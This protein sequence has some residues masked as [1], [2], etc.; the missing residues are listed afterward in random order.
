MTAKLNCPSCG[1]QVPFQS[2]ASVSATCPYCRSVLVRTDMK[3]EEIGKVAKLMDDMT[4]LQIGT[5]GRYKGRSFILLGRARWQWSAGFWNEWHLSYGGGASGWLAEA[6]GFM[7]VAHFEATKAVPAREK[8]KVGDHLVL[9][10]GKYQVEDMKEASCV[11]TEGEL[12]AIIKPG[13][14]KRT[15]DLTANLAGGVAGFASIDYEDDGPHVYVG[16]YEDVESLTLS[17]L[18]Q[19]DGW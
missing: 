7:G 16:T 1:A 13:T 17:N 12:P 11:G 19:L 4:A 10:G 6:Q 5:Q 15:V 14:K 9:P 2:Q 3:L 18:R 8:L